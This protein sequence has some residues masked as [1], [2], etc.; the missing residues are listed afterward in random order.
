MENVKRGVTLVEVMIAMTILAIAT[1]G[2]V[3]AIIANSHLSETNK[4]SVIA[5]QAAR[6]AINDIYDRQAPR[7]FSEY[8]ARYNAM[9]SDD[10][11]ENHVDGFPN[12]NPGDIFDICDF[13][14]CS[15]HFNNRQYA[16]P[17]TCGYDLGA[18]Y[19]N[20]VL[21]PYTDGR[22]NRVR[23][24]PASVDP[25][26]AADGSKHTGRILFPTVGGQLRE[27]FRV[28]SGGGFDERAGYPAGC[29]NYN[30]REKN[31][32]EGWGGAMAPPLNHWKPGTPPVPTVRG[33]MGPF[34]YPSYYDLNADPNTET[35]NPANHA[36]DYK[37][38]PVIILIRWRGFD[39]EDHEFTLRSLLVDKK[40]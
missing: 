32:V 15:A 29:A 6:R 14:A 20:Q 13:Y 5:A 21:I 7:T 30:N 3:M 16:L 19:C 36:T 12:D 27:T 8:F 22:P 39:G 34:G 26:T 2:A 18:N 31:L 38:L 1:T 35:G 10:I 4:E 23:L 28:N 33:L 11:P 17:G 37:M 40:L 9:T 25:V 24:D